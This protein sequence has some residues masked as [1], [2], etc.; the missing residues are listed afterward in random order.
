MI[1][2]LT[3]QI[4]KHLGPQKRPNPQ[5]VLTNPLSGREFSSH[6]NDKFCDEADS[7]HNFSPFVDFTLGLFV[8]AEVAKKKAGKKYPPAMVYS[9]PATIEM[10][11][12]NKFS[13]EFKFIVENKSGKIVHRMFEPSN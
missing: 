5:P 6:V 9:M 8:G 2:W 3:F 4:P 12:G 1:V 7:F 13:G 10:L 11:N